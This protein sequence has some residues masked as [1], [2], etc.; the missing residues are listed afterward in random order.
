MGNTCTCNCNKNPSNNPQEQNAVSFHEEDKDN[1]SND[2]CDYN[3]MHNKHLINNLLLLKKQN[4]S[5]D[6]LQT[7]LIEEENIM[8]DYIGSFSPKNKSFKF[9]N[10]IITGV[11]NSASWSST[12]NTNT[13]NSNGNVMLFANENISFN[14]NSGSLNNNHLDTI[15]ELINEN[16]VTLISKDFNVNNNNYLINQRNINKQQQQ[17]QQQQQYIEIDSYNSKANAAFKKGIHLNNGFNNNNSNNCNSNSNNFNKT[18]THKKSHSISKDKLP[19]SYRNDNNNINNNNSS[20]VHNINNSNNIRFKIKHKPTL[21]NKP[22]PKHNNIKIEQLIPNSKLDSKD[23]NEIIYQGELLKYS[24]NTDYRFAHLLTYRYL[25]LTRNE[26][27]IYR[28][29]E[30]FLHMKQPIL[31]IN[32]KN[33]IRVEKTE[34]VEL[35]WQKKKNY[36]CFY[37]EYLSLSNINSNFNKTNCAGLLCPSFETSISKIPSTDRNNYNNGKTSHNHSKSIESFIKECKEYNFTIK[38]ES[39]ASSSKISKKMGLIP[40]KQ[41]TSSVDGVSEGLEDD[42]LFKSSIDG[43]L[44]VSEKEEVIDKWVT[45]INYMIKELLK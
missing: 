37:L 19:L 20:N 14:P 24:K 25:L 23:S 34:I 9:N 12:N 10:K 43:V 41:G 28:S 29:K 15:S 4:E 21:S 26:L 38:K 17:Q 39:G 31:S 42:T 5:T 13:N 8:Q 22:N 7:S 2:D 30:I 32:L 40:D 44:L 1:H 35:L 27:K 16:T 6:T 3:A 33:V 11:I 45:V 36:S 18:I